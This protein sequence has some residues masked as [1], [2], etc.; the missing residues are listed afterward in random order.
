MVSF[1]HPSIRNFTLALKFVEP[2]ILIACAILAYFLRHN[3]ITAPEGYMVLTAAGTAG[4]VTLA[5]FMGL[6]RTPVL[7]NIAG[8]F[9]K[10]LTAIFIS[11]SAV[12]M[13]MFLLKIA[14]TYSRTW[15]VIWLLASIV[16]LLANR[17]WVRHIVI[18]NMK[19]GAWRRRTAI[20]GT[21]PKATR[22]IERFGDT[23]TREV[24][25]V[26]IYSID[27]EADE[28]FCALTKF[29]GNIYDL[30]ADCRR[31][32]IDDVILAADLDQIKDAE[33]LLNV[34]HTLSVNVL[35]CLPVSLFGKTWQSSYGPV[36]YLY[37]RALEGPSI[38]LKRMLDIVMSGL[39]LA[40]F[41][42]VM[43]VIAVLIK[44]ESK[45][46]VF[47]RQK[48]NGFNGEEFEMLKFRSMRPGE[49]VLDKDGKEKQ[50]DKNDNRITRVGKF[51]RK[52]SLDELPQLINVLRGDMSIV[53]P[54]P[55]AI[56]HNIHYEN[57]IERYASRHKMRPG[58]TGWAQLNGWRGET[59]TLDKMAKRIEYDIWYIE[60]WSLA[61]D[62]KI[63]VMT[64][65]VLLF[66]KQAY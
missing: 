39:A 19:A 48:R 8:T 26:G 63:I 55:H 38:W 33:K 43:L 14:Q 53:G 12:V 2:L 37:R 30:C 44:L 58:L 16:G 23:G 57:R 17:V 7:V 34:L 49:V 3:S 20:L 65:L 45:G 52:S 59:D 61:L 32:T 41:A 15:V 13:G 25:L 29:K 18:S 10:T 28:D 9:L 31:D 66:Q 21:G 22:L 62:L 40:V 1:W 6:Y 35:Y 24:N 36:I 56:S 50:A 60:N 4:Y 27:D 5:S 47:F 51:I 54:R 11:F 42:P 46:P 64:P